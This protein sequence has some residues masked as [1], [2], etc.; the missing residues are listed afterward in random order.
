MRA[1][2]GG[3]TGGDVD[4]KDGMGWG[5]GE[6]NGIREWVK[7]GT[8]GVV[9]VRDGVAREGRGPKCNGNEGNRRGEVGRSKVVIRVNYMR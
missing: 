1:L 3:G 7:G 5:G 4:M 2:R 8:G 6:S 9:G